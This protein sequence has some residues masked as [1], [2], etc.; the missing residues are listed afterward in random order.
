MLG[1]DVEAGAEIE[2]GFLAGAAS[3]AHGADEAVVGIAG[4]IGGAAVGGAANEH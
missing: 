1:G 2:Q 3:D 4:A